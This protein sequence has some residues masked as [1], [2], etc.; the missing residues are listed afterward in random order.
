[1]PNKELRTLKNQTPLE[2][3]VEATTLLVRPVR[4]RRPTP[5]NT[6]ELLNLERKLESVGRSLLAISAYTVLRVLHSFLSRTCQTV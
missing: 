6:M 4:K 1:M 2:E 3:V 5:V